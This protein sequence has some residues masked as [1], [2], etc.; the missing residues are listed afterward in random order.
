[1]AASAPKTMETRIFFS[2]EHDSRTALLLPRLIRLFSYGE[3]PRWRGK[4]RLEREPLYRHVGPLVGIQQRR[5]SSR[6][7]G[8][9]HFSAHPARIPPCREPDH[10]I[11]EKADNRQ[12]KPVAQ[13]ARRLVF[14]GFLQMGQ[15]LFL[16]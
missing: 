2:L 10:Q 1:M 15:F 4:L 8:S 13:T 7:S 5:L 12:Q 3:K 14:L 16:N 11:G 6:L 9:R